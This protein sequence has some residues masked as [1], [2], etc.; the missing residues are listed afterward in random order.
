[1]PDATPQ[2]KRD[3]EE[4]GFAV[5]KGAVPPERAAQY[6]QRAL[7]W[8]SQF[9]FDKDDK[10]TWTAD[11]L[12]VGENGLCN[13]YG[14]SHE[15][16]VWD[17]R[18]EPKVVETFEELWGTHEL[19]VSFDAVNFSLPVGPHGRTDL[20]PA[21]PWPHMDQQPAPTDRPALQFELA[22]GLLAMTKSGPLDGGLVVLEGS[23]KLLPQF[24][25][26]TGG[27]K[28]EQ[29]WGARNYYTFTPTDLAWFKR[30]PGVVEVKVESAPGDLVLW[31]SR[32]IHWN[33]S[34]TA[35]QVRVVVYVC[36]APRS[37]ASDE[38][39]GKRRECWEKRRATTHWPAPFIVVPRDEYG[40][41]QRNGVDDPRDHDRPL[42]EPRETE[43][44]LR[45]VG[46]LPY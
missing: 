21:A 45:L 18:L 30:Q 25:A 32:L 34:P 23:H 38:V 42:E 1:M 12:P 36:Y 15:A 3:L 16:W 9:G 29:D 14:V 20:Q 26:E 41:P 33:R 10:S 37:M 43:Q 39:L 8:A 31:D 7:K 44:L 11:H 28:Q 5:V 6:E 24:F 2:W 27:V 35:D 40:P 22:Q 13:D 17:A 46:V 4:N 19:L